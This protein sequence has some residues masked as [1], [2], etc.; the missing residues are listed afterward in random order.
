GQIGSPDLDSVVNYS[1]YA[2]GL[3]RDIDTYPPG[4]AVA[5]GWTT[6]W[7]P[8]VDVGS[9]V[10]GGRTGVV[11]RSLVTPAPGTVPAAAVRREFVRGPGA[12]R[13]DPPIQV[14]EGGEARGA[15]ARFTLPAG[16]DPATPLVLDASSSVVQA[17]VWD[18]Q[19]WVPIELADAPPP[20]AGGPAGAEAGAAPVDG[21]GE[22]TSAILVAPAAP[23]GVAQPLPPPPIE[24]PGIDTFG[25]ARLAAL[26]AGSL[27]GGTVYVRVAMSPNM[28]SRLVLQVRGAA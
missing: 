9:R 8:P 15:V 7:S 13:F 27:Q 23:D 14:F 28:S 25:S 12:T 26:P 20:A 18:G 4:V 6:G 21:R 5:A 3:G 17:E 11:A 22:S 10:V 2:A 16:T 19:A 1:V 24:G